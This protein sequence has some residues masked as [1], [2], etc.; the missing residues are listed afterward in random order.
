MLQSRPQ[1]GKQA[2]DLNI[3]HETGLF[4]FVMIQITAV[5]LDANKDKTIIEKN[6]IPPAHEK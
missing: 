4:D 5:S 2:L 6:V 1:T 3:T